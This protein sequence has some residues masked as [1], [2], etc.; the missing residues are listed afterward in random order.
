MLRS[1]FASPA[2]LSRVRSR[3]VAR[4][5]LL[6]CLAA[7]PA[8]NA[9]VCNFARDLDA[10]VVR[11]R[12]VTESGD[13]APF[14][15]ARFAGAGLVRQADADGAF[16][17]SGMPAGA[18]FVRVTSD[19]D[20]DGRDDLGHFAVAQVAVAAH[21]SGYFG[22]SAETLTGVD[23]GD[24]ALLPLRTLRAEIAV[25]DGAGPV[26]P[27]TLGL[28]AGLAVLRTA[29]LPA[30][31]ASRVGARCEEGDVEGSE[32]VLP[33]E[34]F[35]FADAAGDVAIEGILD[36]EVQVVVVVA[37]AGVG[38]FAPVATAVR[39][40]VV[41]VDGDEN[42]GALVVSLADDAG[43]QE[44][45]LASLST[46]T[47]SAYAVLSPL[48]VASPPCEA[49]PPALDAPF[50]VVTGVSDGPPHQ[51]TLPFGVYDLTVCADDDT[52]AVHAGL[53][54]FADDG[55]PLVGPLFGG[56]P[57]DCIG[58]VDG[59]VAR[60]CDGDGLRGLPP[61][62]PGAPGFDDDRALWLACADLC[63]DGELDTPGTFGA[64]LVASCGVSGVTYDC[65]DDADG[66]PDVTE[67]PTC[68]VPFAGTD[69]DGDGQCATADPF[70]RCAGNAACDDVDDFP[71]AVTDLVR[72]EGGLCDAF[73]DVAPE[74][75]EVCALT[76]TGVTRCTAFF[77][78]CYDRGCFGDPECGPDAVCATLDDDTRCRATCTLAPDTCASGSTCVDHGDNRLFC[79]EDAP[80][81]PVQRCYCDD[82]TLFGEDSPSFVVDGAGGCPAD[83]TALWGECLTRW[84]DTGRL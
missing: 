24:I 13:P 74:G 84:A 44:I 23:L 14:A 42:L 61:L 52:R 32:H 78:R 80:L 67:P 28:R 40:L 76:G 70:P 41:T 18:S 2:V 75:D 5:A 8:C 3:L 51:V 60:D 66:Q 29:C 72:G 7:L 10:G 37:P 16:S 81:G 17:S 39:R 31:A 47:V 64:R 56:A 57:L 12:A 82:E 73:V 26:A 55:V 45:A 50:V 49:S 38:A 36:G 63:T 34:G 21:A 79:E 33:V 59:D 54:V 25:D 71:P 11:G 53:A 30:D 35:A 4:G 77:L 43:D 22:S 65:D 20:G 46:T 62:L 19:V 68:A 1:T 69:L 15:I 58:E 9:L 83:T 27:E 48:G 6:A